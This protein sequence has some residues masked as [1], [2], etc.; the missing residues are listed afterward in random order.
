[1]C[2]NHAR[3][4]A[5]PG[6]GRA[7]EV[8]APPPGQRPVEGEGMPW[9]NC[10]AQVS[11][12]VT[13]VTRVRGGGGEAGG[14]EGPVTGE[15]SSVSRHVS[16]AGGTCS[17]EPETC[18]TG[19]GRYAGGDRPRRTRRLQAVFQIASDQGFLG[20]I[21]STARVRR[22]DSEG[23]GCSKD[24]VPSSFQARSSPRAFTRGGCSKRAQDTCGRSKLSGRTL[25]KL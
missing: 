12:M 15:A 21:A 18:P 16:E 6:G 22:R 7:A 14:C 13:H 10:P 2:I 5:P 25:L 24:A 4:A 11:P 9:T 3:S 19:I 20:L 8:P 1:M 17:G 23:E